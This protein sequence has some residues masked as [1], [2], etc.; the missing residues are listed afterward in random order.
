MKLAV[1]TNGLEVRQQR[2][3]D[4]LGIT[5][6]FDAILISEVE[7]VKKPDAEIFERAATRGRVR[8]LIG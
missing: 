6:W 2:K 1:I 7:G 8:H 3:M 4:A 5:T